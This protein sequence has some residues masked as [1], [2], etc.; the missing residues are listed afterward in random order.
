LPDD[1]HGVTTIRISVLD[2][3][4]IAGLDRAGPPGF[5]DRRTGVIGIHFVTV[6]G[7]PNP[8]VVI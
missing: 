4:R 3:D 7:D 8:I 1:P 2:I 5:R 6:D